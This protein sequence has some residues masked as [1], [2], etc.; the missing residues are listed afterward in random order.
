[1][2]AP[3]LGVRGDDGIG[4]DDGKAEPARGGEDGVALLARNKLGVEIAGAARR[5]DALEEGDVA[6]KEDEAVAIEGE[7]AGEEA[8]SLVTLSAAKGTISRHG[9]LR[10][11]QA[12]NV[13]LDLR[14]VN[15][16]DRPAERRP[17][18]LIDRERD[19]LLVVGDQVRA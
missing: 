15:R 14:P 3:I 12:D 4:R 10:F 19:R 6:R 17:P 5:G 8:S 11:A 13:P 1:M 18:P 2:A 9:R 7:L 16:R